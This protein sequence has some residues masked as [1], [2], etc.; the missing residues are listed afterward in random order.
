MG[1]AEDR[2]AI[3]DLAALYMRALD[4]LDEVLE[5]RVADD[6]PGIPATMHDH[7]FDMFRRGDTQADGSGVGLALVATL[8][9]RH[10]GRLTLDSDEGAGA[11][12]TVTWPLAIPKPKTAHRR[13]S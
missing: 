7:I 12:F 3:I 11:V 8:V 10:G 4:R 1:S 13:A 9:R 2:F 6:G 5:L